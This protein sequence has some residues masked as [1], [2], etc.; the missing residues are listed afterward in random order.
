MIKLKNDVLTTKA[1]RDER[2]RKGVKKNF[3]CEADSAE[4]KR[5]Q[6]AKESCN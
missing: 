1:L 3:A 2:R 6:A 4:N 5:R